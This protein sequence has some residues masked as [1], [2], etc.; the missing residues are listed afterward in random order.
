[1]TT[2]NCSTTVGYIQQHKAPFWK[3]IEQPEYCIM[4]NQLGGSPLNFSK[5][6]ICDMCDNQMAL[7]CQYSKNINNR[8]RTVYCFACKK[9]CCTISVIRINRHHH[10]ATLAKEYQG[11]E[12]VCCVKKESR[13]PKNNMKMFKRYELLVDEEDE[14]MEYSMDS[15]GI[16]MYQQD[17]PSTVVRWIK[18]KEK[19]FMTD[20]CDV[21]FKKCKCGND[22]KLECQILPNSLYYLKQKEEL[23][24]IDFGTILIGCCVGNCGENDEIHLDQGIRMQFKDPPKNDEGIYDYTWMLKNRKEELED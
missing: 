8:V 21:Q 7:I 15:I 2:A 17:Y 10:Q 3:N 20:I 18:E 14:E 12:A 1:M 6:Q 11:L 24:S 13:N 16:L 19:V 9:D 4:A 23:H 22:R 5:E